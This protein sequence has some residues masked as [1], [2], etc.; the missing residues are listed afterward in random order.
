[1]FLCKFFMIKIKKL[2]FQLLSFEPLLD[3]KSKP[4][5]F[6][7]IW[8]KI[9]LPSGLK[10]ILL[11]YGVSPLFLF[12]NSDGLKLSFNSSESRFEKLIKFGF[13]DRLYLFLFYRCLVK[14]KFLISIFYLKSLPLNIFAYYESLISFSN[15]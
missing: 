15:Y 5:D 7:Y 6:P 10:V 13:T 9:L 3:P 1:M 12:I 2:F 4:K 8:L 14:F 11:F